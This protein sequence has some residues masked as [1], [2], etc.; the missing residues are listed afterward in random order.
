MQSDPDDVELASG[1]TTSKAGGPAAQHDHGQVG[2]HEGALLSL[3]RSGSQQD[4]DDAV[5][6]LSDLSE[7]ESRPGSS[8][9][10][11]ASQLLLMEKSSFS[12]GSA[13]VVNPLFS[14]GAAAPSHA[15]PAPR[16][17][18]SAESSPDN[19]ASMSDISSARGHA[20]ADAEQEEELSRAPSSGSSAA[21]LYVTAR[22]DFGGSMSR[23]QVSDDLADQVS[24]NSD[25]A[26]WPQPMEDASVVLSPA[27]PLYGQPTMGMFSSGDWSFALRERQE[28]QADSF[29]PLP[30]PAN[31]LF[32]R[33]YRPLQM[34]LNYAEGAV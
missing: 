10:A 6:Q 4:D 17:E 18:L 11:E 30:C 25:S 33:R 28:Q 27:N 8:L 9:D 2:R 20:A 15:Q 29:R 7:A 19:A 22:G 32:G 31:P 21:S 23:S 16:P 26:A 12:F 14:D 5:S 1:D 34:T 13:P 3:A 24:S